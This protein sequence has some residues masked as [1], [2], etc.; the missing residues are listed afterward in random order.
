MEEKEE[1][2]DAVKGIERTT[3]CKHEWV[4]VGMNGKLY[5]YQCSKCW[6]GINAERKLDG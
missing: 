5:D 1:S 3:D 2:V 6:S 4:F